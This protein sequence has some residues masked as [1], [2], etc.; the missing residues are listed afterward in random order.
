[1][2][3]P[4]FPASFRDCRAAFQAAALEAG[5]DWIEVPVDGRGP[6]GEALTIAVA[7]LGPSDAQRVIGLQC[8]IHG[9]EGPSGSAVMVQTLR[10]GVLAGHRAVLVHG[11]NPFGFA[12]QRRQTAG[13][14]DLNRNFLDWSG[15]P[16]DRPVYGEL[17]P[18]LNPTGPTPPDIAPFLSAASAWIDR[19][20]L[21]WVQA[22][23][24]EGQ[25]QYPHGLYFGGEG[26]DS[27]N[28]ALRTIWRR[29][30]AGAREAVVTD[31]HTG[32]G[33]PGRWT[34][35]SATPAGSPGT[36]RLSG[37]FGPDRVVATSGSSDPR[38]TRY[39]DVSGRFADALR[40]EAPHCAT[41]AC[42]LE[43]GTVDEMEA[44]VAERLENWLWHHGDRT[45]P[46]G[47][48]IVAAH[49]ACFDP[50]APAWQRAVLDG[51]REVIGAVA[52]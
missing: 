36:A 41:A 18:I 34:A 4:L 7:S 10:Q 42:S 44:I 17:D 2:S 14:V 3:G 11:A 48:A 13:N 31:F 52:G 26:P 35:L 47:Q 25:Y 29:A 5:A 15:K 19:H 22:R 28:M 45:S 37:L 40:E 12:W 38:D 20:G 49:A 43:F 50:P 9:V 46:E 27:A 51:G 32:L 8:G 33:P 39:P 24:A 23:V 16:P 6:D 30:L 21:A 1:V